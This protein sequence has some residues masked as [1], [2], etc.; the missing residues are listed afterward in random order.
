MKEKIY[1]VAR[2]L[3]KADGC[4]W[5]EAQHNAS[6]IVYGDLREMVWKNMERGC[7]AEDALSL[8]KGQMLH[9]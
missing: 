1:E 3:M 8:A 2:Y 7:N 9:K 5:N 6:I 4:S